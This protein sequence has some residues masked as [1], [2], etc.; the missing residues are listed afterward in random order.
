MSR[1]RTPRAYN[2]PV[3]N[4]GAGGNDDIHAN[5]DIPADMHGLVDVIVVDG[6]PFS[7]VVV[8]HGITHE[9]TADMRVLAYKKSSF[10]PNMDIVSKMDI[11]FYYSPLKT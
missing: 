6:Q 7:L 11:F 5:P 3:L 10:R 9:V 8:V 2:D 1:Y 4:S